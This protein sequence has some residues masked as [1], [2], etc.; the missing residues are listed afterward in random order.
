M[1]DP[2]RSGP[3]LCHGEMRVVSLFDLTNGAMET[4]DPAA[5]ICLTCGVTR[6]AYPVAETQLR[7]FVDQ[8]LPAYLVRVLQES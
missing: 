5:F 4:P 8:Y 3:Y 6:H 7:A 2:D 1:S